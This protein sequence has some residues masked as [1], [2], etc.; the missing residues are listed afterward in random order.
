MTEASTKDQLALGL[1]SL[2]CG[3][4]MGAV[5]LISAQILIHLMVNRMDPADYPVIDPARAGLIA[6]VGVG[7]SFAWYRSGPLENLWQRG[8]IAVLASV[9]ALL[10]GFIAAPLENFIGI[11]AMFIWLGINLAVGLAGSAWAIKGKGG[12]TVTP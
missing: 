10:S 11:K 8:V 7:G 5:C 12:D 4:G 2:L 1:G 3:V 6:A 9:G